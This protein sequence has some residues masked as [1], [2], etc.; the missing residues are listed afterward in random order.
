MELCA[1]RLV[2]MCDIGPCAT[3]IC[4]CVCEVE[5]R[6]Q[7]LPSIFVIEEE[8]KQGLLKIDMYLA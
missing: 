7:L 4:E 5:I 1:N 3:E 8:I 2:T 6:E